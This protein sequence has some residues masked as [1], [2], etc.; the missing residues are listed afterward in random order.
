M[1]GYYGDPGG[2]GAY[3]DDSEYAEAPYMVGGYGYGYAP[4]AYG[5]GLPAYGFGCPGGCG[6]CR[7]RH[8]RG[9]RAGPAA[10]P[11]PQDAGVGYYGFYGAPYPRYGAAWGDPYGLSGPAAPLAP[12]FGYPGFAQSYDVEDA[13]GAYADEDDFAAPAD[14]DFAGPFAAD[15]M[16]AYEGYVPEGPSPYNYRVNGLGEDELE[17]YAP[18]APVSPTCSAL[19]PS[20][21]PTAELPDT[22][23]PLW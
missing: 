15:E 23:R 1:M 11:A 21:Q 8:A 12:G 16:E 2:Y 17:G 20:P 7:C 18:T 3:A 5:Y 14:E 10:P 19:R 4:A 13:Y 9:G 22:L 6:A